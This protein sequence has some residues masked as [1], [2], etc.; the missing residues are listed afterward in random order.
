[1]VVETVATDVDSVIEEI[2]NG[3]V[4]ATVDVLVEATVDVVETSGGGCSTEITSP[5]GLG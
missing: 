5:K 2:D 4:E 3:L 1:M